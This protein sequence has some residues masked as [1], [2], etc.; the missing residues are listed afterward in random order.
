[1][2]LVGSDSGEMKLYTYEDKRLIHFE[3]VH[4]TGISAVAIS[5]DNTLILTADNNG[6]IFFWR[7]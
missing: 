5:P 2:L 7:I 4:G 1:L 3:T 6:H